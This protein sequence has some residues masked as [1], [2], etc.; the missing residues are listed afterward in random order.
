M[1]AVEV[2]GGA[3]VGGRH[4]RGKGFLEDLRKYEAAQR[5]GWTIYRTAGELIKSG[6]ALKTIEQLIRAARELERERSAA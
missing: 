5:M 2:E 4:T 6:N 3:W 1:L